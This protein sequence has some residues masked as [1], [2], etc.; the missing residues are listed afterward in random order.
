MKTRKCVNPQESSNK[1]TILHLN[2]DLT[3]YGNSFS[4][5][6][7]NAPDVLLLHSW[8]DNGNKSNMNNYNKL[9][10]ENKIKYGIY[11]WFNA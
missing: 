5:D 8:D 7:K 4:N 9:Y 3:I 2:D 1:Y 6:S 10:H 11:P